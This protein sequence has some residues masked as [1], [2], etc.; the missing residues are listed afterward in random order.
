MTVTFVNGRQL[1]PWDCVRVARQPEA[2]A[3]TS[4]KPTCRYQSGQL[5]RSPFLASDMRQARGQEHGTGETTAIDDWDRITIYAK[6]SAGW[7]M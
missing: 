6:L 7:S 1:L 3:I 2:I 5:P 4:Y